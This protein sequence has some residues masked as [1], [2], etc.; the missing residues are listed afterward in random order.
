V[1]G[2]LLGA[3][4]DDSRRLLRCLILMG[5][6]RMVSPSRMIWCAASAFEFHGLVGSLPW[7]IRLSASVTRSPF[8]SR[9][10]CRCRGRRRGR[11]RR[12]WRAAPAARRHGSGVHR[13]RGSPGHHG[14][15]AIRSL[16][17][18]RPWHPRV[19]DGAAS[20]GACARGRTSA[21]VL[22]DGLDA[23]RPSQTARQ[24][25]SDRTHAGD[26]HPAG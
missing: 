19:G 10:R 5:P 7:L 12:V 4:D 18:T 17:A 25:R 9:P 24:I 3:R 8:W 16:T 1:Q 21:G 22:A 20:A 26:D 11:G 2:G 6:M 13:Q 15:A 14:L 23:W